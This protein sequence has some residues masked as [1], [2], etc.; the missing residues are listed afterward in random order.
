M[1]SRDDRNIDWR[2][3]GGAVIALLG[4]VILLGLV[5]VVALS[6]SKRDQALQGERHAYDVVLLTRTADAT[7]SR[8]EAALGR[9]VLDENE[10]ITG[11]IYYSQ[12]RL[13]EQQIHQLEQQVRGDPAQQR[14]VAQLKMLFD[15]RNAELVPAARADRYSSRDQSQSPR[16][17]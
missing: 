14:R 13:A 4:A 2:G 10:K 1:A 3:G 7:M 15:R 11:N 17:S 9:F 16:C 5:F 6:N 8:S 12:W